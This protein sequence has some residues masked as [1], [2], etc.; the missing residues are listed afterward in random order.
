MFCSLFSSMNNVHILKFLFISNWIMKVL[1]FTPCHACRHACYVASVVSD[2]LHPSGLWRAWLLCP[3]DSL[4]MNTGVGCHALLQGIFLT[5]GSN[6]CLL[7]LLHWKAGTLP[8]VSPG[9]LTTYDNLLLL[10]RLSRDILENMQ[11]RERRLQ[12]KNL[13]KDHLWACQMEKMLPVDF[14]K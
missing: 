5:Q 8:I 4:G 11:E 2:S 13:K 7:C 9:K 10:S 14:F 3:R 1:F 6:P 12:E